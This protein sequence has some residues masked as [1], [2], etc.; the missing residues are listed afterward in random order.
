MQLKNIYI[1]TIIGIIFTISAIMWFGLEA[2][3]G[4]TLGM[5]A[6]WFIVACITLLLGYIL[7]V[8]N[9][10]HKLLLNIVLTIGVIVHAF[11]IVL[12]YLFKDIRLW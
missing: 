10:K 2:D 8:T 7:N 11:V 1:Y 6:G 9:V 3:I 12:W 4:I 5:M